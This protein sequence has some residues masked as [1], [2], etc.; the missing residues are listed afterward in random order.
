MTRALLCSLWLFTGCQFST[1]MPAQAAG[2][3]GHVEG[4]WVNGI[5]FRGGLVVADAYFHNGRDAVVLTTWEDPT[6]EDLGQVADGHKLE[7]P[8]SRGS[9]IEKAR[10]FA[11]RA[12][13]SG[14]L[15][16]GAGDADVTVAIERMG[17]HEGDAVTGR[18]TSDEGSVS[19][20]V[21]RCGPA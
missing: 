7:V 17:E 6:C 1:D 9:A 2:P 16:N 3:T 21:E 20:D 19:F 4:V 13:P 5:E 10:L 11:C 14:R 8:V 12:L 18:I 15:C